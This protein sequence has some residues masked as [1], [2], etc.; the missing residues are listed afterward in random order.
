[1]TPP[2]AQLPAIIEPTAPTAI[3]PRP[4]TYIVPALIMEA[5]GD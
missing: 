5:G 1:M 4:D 3:A 2:D